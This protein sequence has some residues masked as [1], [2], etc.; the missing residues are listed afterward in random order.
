MLYN[1]LFKLFIWSI[2]FFS[3]PLFALH[4]IQ[5]NSDI[6]RFFLILRYEKLSAFIT[7][8]QSKIFP[9]THEIVINSKSSSHTFLPTKCTISA[10]RVWF[11]FNERLTSMISGSIYLDC[12]FKTYKVS[13]PVGKGLIK[14]Y[15]DIL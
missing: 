10:N 9:S 6:M 8:S 1:Y 3:I 4:S 14:L 12:G 11:G 5:S 15:K 13:F 2:I 7:K